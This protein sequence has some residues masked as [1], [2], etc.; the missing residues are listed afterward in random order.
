MGKKAKKV[1]E[2]REGEKK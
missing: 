2:S 1:L